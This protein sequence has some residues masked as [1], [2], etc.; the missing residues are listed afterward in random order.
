M[1]SV[2]RSLTQSMARARLLSLSVSDLQP[3][4][5]LVSGTLPPLQSGLSSSVDQGGVRRRE[6]LRASFS[7][8]T[9]ESMETESE[10][11]LSLSSVPSTGRDSLKDI[12]AVTDS[13]VTVRSLL[14][15]TVNG[16]TSVALNRN[17]K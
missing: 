12:S 8:V 14:P 15:S 2:G 3:E 1:V 9:V 11:R 10:R 6:G 17:V 16:R 13:A 4:E 5:V 7:R